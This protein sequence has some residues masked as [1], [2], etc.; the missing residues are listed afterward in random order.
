MTPA[1][2]DLRALVLAIACLICASTGT[3]AENSALRGLGTAN[4]ALA[5]RAI[6]RLDAQGSG[7]CT[8]TLIDPETI[9]TAAHCVFSAVTG[10]P[11][12]PGDMLFRAGYREGDAA[13]QRGVVQIEAH[14]LYRP[15][16]AIDAGN[17]RHDVALLRLDAPVSLQ[18]ADPF[19][20][21]EST[22]PAGI[23][24]VVSYGRGRENLPSRQARC[25]V[26]GTHEG[27]VT[28]D[29]DVTFGSSGAPVLSSDGGRGRI[30]SMISGQGSIEG[31]FVAFGMEL[32]ALVSDL[33]RQL[34]ANAARTPPTIRRVRPDGETVGTDAPASRG[35]GAKFVRAPGG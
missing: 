25:Q 14:P 19:R 34:R 4:E 8:A 1:C 5:W 3:M 13:A 35:I 10:E 33:R 12:M 7:F 24:S 18:E 16:V 20:L 30:V 6:G 11:M 22:A 17:V 9:L 31:R 28:M 32:P 21:D 29:C 2:P 23:V 27:I 15:G 26:L